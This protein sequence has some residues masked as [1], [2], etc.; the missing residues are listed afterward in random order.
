LLKNKIVNKNQ[1]FIVKKYDCENINLIFMFFHIKF[2]IYVFSLL[3]NFIVQKFSNFIVKKLTKNVV[4]KIQK[5][6]R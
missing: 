1:V 3:K 6:D 5:K 4:K 2:N